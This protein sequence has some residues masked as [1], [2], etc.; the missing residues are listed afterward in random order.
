L[1]SLPQ[2]LLA[3]LPATQQQA[4]LSGSFGPLVFVW[5]QEHFHFKEGSHFF[6]T[7]DLF[8]S[9]LPRSSKDRQYPLSLH[10]WQLVCLAHP[11]LENANT[12]E[13]PSTTVA[14]EMGN[15]VSR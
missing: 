4:A 12:T 3:G 10:S 9:Q 6:S 13:M 15:E 2:I 1:L 8:A 11:A 14:T 5:L 7:T